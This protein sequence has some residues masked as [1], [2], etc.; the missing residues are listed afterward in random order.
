[1]R[2][3]VS[4]IVIL[5]ALFA[6]CKA[7]TVSYQETRFLNKLKKHDRMLWLCEFA[8]VAQSVVRRI[9]SAE[10]SS[11]I[12]DSSSGGALRS[13]DKLVSRFSFFYGGAV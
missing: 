11:S 4:M 12:L 6:S 5:C 10:V 7:E 3:T 9:G 13:A 2:K 8:V 1:M